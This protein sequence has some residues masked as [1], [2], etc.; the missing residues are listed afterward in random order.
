MIG[1]YSR[2][3]V[4]EPGP[5]TTITGTLPPALRKWWPWIAV[6]LALGGVLYLSR[7]RDKRRPLAGGAG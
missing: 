5:D 7:D 2:T 6:A 4:V 1:E 3:I